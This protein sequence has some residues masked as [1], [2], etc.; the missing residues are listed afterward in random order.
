MDTKEFEDMKESLKVFGAPAML[1]E[2]LTMVFKR[3]RNTEF[4]HDSLAGY[5]EGLSC[6]I[7][8]LSNEQS[9]ETVIKEIL[10]GYNVG[11]NLWKDKYERPSK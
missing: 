8:I 2:T 3:N 9:I 11:E 4:N 5:L 10:S 6:A 7:H 1:I